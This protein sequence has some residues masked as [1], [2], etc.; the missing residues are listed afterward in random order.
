LIFQRERDGVAAYQLE[1]FYHG[2]VWIAGKAQGE[3][4]TLASTPGVTQ[5]LVSDAMSE[6][7]IPPPA[8]DTPDGSWA[9]VRGRLAPFYMIQAQAQPGAQA[10]RHVFLMPVDV[11]RALGGNLSAMRALLLPSFPTFERAGG[12]LP[13][14]P[15][16]QAG[17]SS[18]ET[19]EAAMFALMNATYDRPDV[20]EAL[21]AALIQ[22]VPI[23]VTGAPPALKERA[24]FIEGLLALLPPPAR[25][26]V[27]FA[28]HTTAATTI[29]V[30]IR[31]FQDGDPPPR[32]LIFDWS[33]GKVMGTRVRDEYARFIKSQLR[34]STGLVID[35]TSALAAVASWRIRRGEKLADAL[36]YASHRRKVD[37]ALMN[38]LPVET[39]EVAKILGEDP[40]LTD[41]LRVIYVKHLIAFA[42][43]LEEVAHSDLLATA[44]RGQPDLERVILQQMNEALA[45]GKSDRVYKRLSRWMKNPLGFRGMYWTEL[46][47][48]AA[49][50]FAEVLAR[51]GDAEKLHL[52]L[53]QF[54]T[55]HNDTQI[56]AIVPQLI[57]IALPLR[58]KSQNLALT[59]FAMAARSLNSDN[60]RRFL[61]IKQISPLPKPLHQLLAQLNAEDN[62]PAAAGLLAKVVSGFTAEW[63][64]LM[65]I[66][67]CEAAVL[68]GRYRLIDAAAATQLAAAALSPWG[69]TYNESLRMIVRTLSVD[70]LLTPLGADGAYP[71]LQIL[72][73]RGAYEELAN[74]LL[75]HARLLYP[76]DRQLD[77]AALLR[78]LFATTPFPM[79][80][81]SP[82]LRVLSSKSLKPL[83]VTMAYFGALEQF[84]YPPTLDG[85]VAELSALVFTNKTIVESLP[86][87]LLLRLLD[88]YVQVRDTNTITRIANLLPTAAARRGVGGVEPLLKLYATLDWEETVRAASMEALRRYVRL[89][90]DNFARQAI[91]RLGE[92]LGREV[93]HMLDATL[94]VRRIMGGESLADYA[95]SLNALSRFLYDT[96]VA[97]T[98]KNRLP[99]ITTLVNDLD[100]LRGGLT[101]D[102]RA[103]LSDAILDFGRM[104]ATLYSQHRKTRTERDA[105]DSDEVLDGLLRGKGN[106]YT[107]I[108]LFRVMGGYFSQNLKLVSRAEREGD[109]HPL[110]ERATHLLLR[111]LQ[112]MTRLIKTALRAFPPDERIVVRAEDIRAEI[113]SLWN[114]ISLAERRTLVKD[115]AADCQRIAELTLTI[116]EKADSRV[117]QDD[118]SAGRKLEQMRQ[119]PENALEL[120]RF[121]RG[122]FR[123]KSR[124]DQ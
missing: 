17:N 59:L 98:D 8:P 78:R 77:F 79:E 112:Q 31:F 61:A 22:G 66:R 14:Q 120:Y 86:P 73:A 85:V 48:R 107:V 83:P 15:L 124:G 25:F 16:E 95:Y 122:Y 100:S 40:T 60:W 29:D 110:G 12:Q 30:Q 3:L 10:V 72:L 58:A 67:L 34:I 90:P 7:R 62:E 92:A 87:E 65:A 23:V 51:N 52:F 45:Q 84:N 118:N 50:S 111:E 19:Q 13:F 105:R 9:L 21:L 101:A 42:L 96:W 46:L 54:R 102:E 38:G 55:V 70:E 57:Q 44:A 116:C 74:E 49:V 11:L 114:D 106:V 123:T 20:I 24:A 89:L 109:P 99:T 121:V 88:Y 64:P 81:V 43:A 26:G 108:D 53:E 91:A 27:T 63:R 82:A 6:A 113:E 75:K 117:L 1:H 80:S 41:E 32:T 18:N 71:L 35:Q 76:P 28:T 104:I 2:Q 97:F 69:E 56:D 47:H 119:R 39:P 5:A 68:A 37:D 36:K 4:Q 103:K 115:L 94:L 93:R 33:A